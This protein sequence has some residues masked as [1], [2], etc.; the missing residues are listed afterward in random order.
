MEY[1]DTRKFRLLVVI[2]AITFAVAYSGLSD[3]GGYTDPPGA[4]FAS[5]A[6]GGP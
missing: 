6:T 3:G 5:E 4:H 2:L 1:D